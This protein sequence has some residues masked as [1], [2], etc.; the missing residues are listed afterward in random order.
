MRVLIVAPNISTRMGGEAVLGY[1]YIREWQELGLDVT[2]LTHARVREELKQSPI[3]REGAFHFVEDAG[4]EH[5]LYRVTRHAPAAV[6]DTVFRSSAIQLITLRRLARRARTLAREIR[7]DIIHQP[8]PVSP[9]MPSFLHDMPAPVVIGP[10]NGGME[11]PP[12]FER[13][14]ARG[15]LGAVKLA[16]G[17]S[18]ALN[19]AFPGK[20]SA[21]R[22]LVAN[23]RTRDALPKRV[24]RE[25]VDIL[26][27]NGVDLDLWSPPPA[28]APEVPTFV[29]VGR[30]V[31]WKA[32][33][34]LIDA[35]ARLETPARLVIVGDGDERTALEA[36]AK[37]A[38]RSDHA[39]DFLGFLPQ[40]EIAGVLAKS[41][42]LVLP[43]L[44]ECGGAVVLEAFACRIPAIATDWGGPQDY[45]TAETGILVPP[46]DEYR[47][48]KGLTEAMARLAADPRGAHVMGEAARRRVE[49]DF[50]W[51][52]KA[53]RVLDVYESTL[54]RKRGETRQPSA[55][56][57]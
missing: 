8:A 39:I 42:A 38:R 25:R 54:S 30:L 15:T 13:S 5:M 10:L 53:R 19:A 33:E 2:A 34:L 41:T 6:Y 27:E 14:H 35:F 9:Q 55:N 40:A 47:F 21:E 43:S 4:T 1:H 12:A 22:I 48:V 49:E 28:P 46:T 52:A 57:T 50:S 20:L 31:W 51:A 16:R 11:Y 29:F 45:I 24:D 56:T 3:W 36:R 26:A 37:T 7:A 17:V 32:V 18:G 23:E 44:R